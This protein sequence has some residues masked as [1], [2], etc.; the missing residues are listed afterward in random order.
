MLVMAILLDQH[1]FA[2]KT[3]RT[4]YCTWLRKPFSS[5]FGSGFHGILPSQPRN[6]RVRA[7]IFHVPVPLL[8]EETPYHLLAIREAQLETEVLGTRNGL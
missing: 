4:G 8:G 6:I 7:D 1:F 5:H 2:R 3:W